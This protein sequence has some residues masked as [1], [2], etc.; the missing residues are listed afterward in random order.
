MLSQPLNAALSST[1]V[2]GRIGFVVHRAVDDNAAAPSTIVC[3]SSKQLPDKTQ[4]HI[5][6]AVRQPA[7]SRSGTSVPAGLASSYTVPLTSTAAGA[8][9]R[10]YLAHRFVKLNATFTPAAL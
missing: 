9:H 10:R 7:P 4:A 6:D 3:T 8:E 5:H 1:S 2:P